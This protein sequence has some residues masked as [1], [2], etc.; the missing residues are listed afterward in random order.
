[1]VIGERL[2]DRLQHV[3][4][5]ESARIVAACCRIVSLRKGVRDRRVVSARR[6]LAV[7]DGHQEGGGKESGRVATAVGTARDMRDDAGALRA[8]SEQARRRAR[9]LIE[10]HEKH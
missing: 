7:A 3:Q 4:P 10:Q 9:Q 5:I 1:M 2:A 6:K 8:Q